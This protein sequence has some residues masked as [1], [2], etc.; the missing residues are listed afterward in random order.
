MTHDR[1][2]SAGAGLRRVHAADGEA[3]SPWVLAVP[4]VVL[5]L[6]AAL[7]GVDVASDARAGG[8]TGHVVLEGVLLVVALAGTAALWAQLFASRRRAGALE[9]DLV[10]AEADLARF[11]AESHDLLRG[12][13]EVIDRQFDRWGLSTAER[14]IALLLLKGLTHKDIASVR[15]TS[16]RTV[17]QQSLAVY[18][19]AGLAGR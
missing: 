13:A 16:E 17:R 10:R 6:V 1:N 18:R 9:R 5:A 14:E 4:A 15:E 3:V 12:L 19:K 7:V 2:Q 11:R 8:S